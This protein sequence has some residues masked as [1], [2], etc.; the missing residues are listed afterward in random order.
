MSER[1]LQDRQKI[2]RSERQIQQLIEETEQRSDT[3]QAVEAS[4]LAQVSELTACIADLEAQVN[5]L[6]TELAK[7][8]HKVNP[9]P[10]PPEPV[11]LDR[12]PA[13]ARAA[14]ESKEGYDAYF[15]PGRPLYD[16]FPQAE[17]PPTDKGKGKQP[18]RDLFVNTTGNVIIPGATPSQRVIPTSEDA[19]NHA[20]HTASIYGQR[21]SEEVTNH[22]YHTPAPASAYVDGYANGYGEGYGAANGVNGDQYPS[23]YAQAQ[24]Y[25]ANT[26]NHNHASNHASTSAYQLPPRAVNPQDSLEN[27]IGNLRLSGSG[28][29]QAA[30]AQPMSRPVESAQ[31][32][33][34]VR[35]RHAY[36]APPPSHTSTVDDASI[37][38]Q[39]GTSHMRPSAFRRSTVQLDGHLTNGLGHAPSAWQLAN[40]PP[41]AHQDVTVRFDIQARDRDENA[42]MTDRRARQERTRQN[43]QSYSSWGTVHTNDSPAT[44]GSMS[45]LEDMPNFPHMR[46]P[47][48]QPSQRNSTASSEGI[49]GHELVTTPRQDSMRPLGFAAGP[50]PAQR[51]AH[52]HSYSLPGNAVPTLED[53]VSYDPNSS[54]QRTTHVNNRQRT[55]PRRFS[56]LPAASEFGMVAPAEQTPVENALGL[57]LGVDAHAPPLI[58][59]PTPRVQMGGFLRSWS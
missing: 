39:A 19:T 37:S 31:A 51:P 18:Q 56:Q 20:H 36:I 16:L 3:H 5:P 1:R 58:T 15:T 6:R 2:R 48:T 43:R 8:Q 46:P 22:A 44:R 21:V 42:R 45:D 33:T 50:A 29:A 53:V 41:T 10:A 40:A 30:I 11:P 17:P 24:A 14:A 23:W 12:F 9:L 57:D 38:S 49:L 7:Y 59:A 26:I 47:P 27:A 32:T 52:T 55:V 25:E 28:A 54:L 35:R 4:L 34:P 13:F